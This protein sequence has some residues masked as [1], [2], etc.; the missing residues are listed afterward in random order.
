MQSAVVRCAADGQP[1]QAAAKQ[2][3]SIAMRPL[4]RYWCYITERIF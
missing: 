4:S 2:N 1:A 3:R